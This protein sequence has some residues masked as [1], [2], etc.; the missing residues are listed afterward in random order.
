M[1]TSK[2][3]T[4]KV[5]AKKVA[6]KKVAAKTIDPAKKIKAYA[7]QEHHFYKGFPRGEAYGIL[8]S[9]KNRTM[10]VG[11]FLDKIEALPKVKS[12]AQ[13]NGILQKLVIKPGDTG[14]KGAV[15]RFV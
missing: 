2:K 3:T 12:R 13:A 14:E 4:K 7:G 9:A 1:T 5:A 6:A 15:C 8:V 10:P 11:E